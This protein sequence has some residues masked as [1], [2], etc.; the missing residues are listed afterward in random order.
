MSITQQAPNTV[1]LGGPAVDVSDL[2]ASATITPGFLIERFN[3]AGVIRLK[4]HSTAGGAAQ[5]MVALD[6]AMANKGIGDD[7]SANDL[8][9]ACIGAPGSVFYMIVP[10][11]Q[12]IVAG[13]FLESA[14]NGKLRIYASGVRLFQALENVTATADT[15]IRAEV[16]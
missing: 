11:G 7:Y 14:G 12:T 2:A 10:S 9:E 3:N 5:T 13:N 6:H 16:I 1:Y 8:V 4:A 15:R